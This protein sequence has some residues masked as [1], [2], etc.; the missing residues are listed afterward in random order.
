M[1]LYD[2]TVTSFCH[3]SIILQRAH[4][5]Q[6]FVHMTVHFDFAP[7]VDE[8]A[9]GVDD[10][11][12]AL[13]ADDLFAIHHFLLDD[14]KLAAQSLFGIADQLERQLQIGLEAVM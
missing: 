9:F 10:K 13:N 1:L 5:R 8:R 6:N 4:K 12:A 14:V 3:V 7:F 2:V 11:G